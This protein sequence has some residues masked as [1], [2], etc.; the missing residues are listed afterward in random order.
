[1]QILYVKYVSVHV[2]VGGA[3]RETGLISARKREPGT[4]YLPSNVREIAHYGGG[5]LMVWAGIMLDSR[6]PLHVFERGT[7]TGVRYRDEILEPYVHLFRGAVGPEFILMD[8]LNARPHRALLVDE[9]L[10]SEDI[11]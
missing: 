9:F 5:G 4:R 7:V 2:C 11:R 3:S 1:M 10:E 6:T 8:D